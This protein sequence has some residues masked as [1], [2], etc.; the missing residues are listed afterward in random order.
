MK[1]FVLL[2]RFPYPLEKGDKLRAYHQIKQLS[3]NHDIHL[4]A[5]ND[6]TIRND[7][8]KALDPYCKSIH[9]L[10][11]S[12]ITI[13]WNILMAFFSGKPL[14]VG[15]FYNLHIQRNIDKLIDEIQPDHI[16]CQLLRVAEYV[17]KKKIPKTLDYQDVFS[18][19]VDRRKEISPFYWKP[20]LKLEYRRLCRYEK[21]LFDDF[22]NKTIISFP[23]RDF[24]P[25]PERNEIVVV[26]NGVDTDYFKPVETEKKYHLIFTGNMGYP[27][28]VNAAVFLVKEILPLIHKILPEVRIILAGAS[29]HTQVMELKSEK[30]EVT[31]WVEDIRP[32]YAS[33]RIF[34]AP[35]QIGTGLQNKLLEAMAMKIPCIT[36]PLA[37]YALGA[38]NGE[39]I[40]VGQTAPELAGLVI[41][42]LNDRQRACQL[43]EN[44]YHFV[45]RNFNWESATNKLEELISK[46]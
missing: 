24:I 27:P 7:Y 18:K 6:I 13:A 37:N 31:G 15:Y 35:M 40:M 2:S 36:S 28:N 17:R 45:H 3:R 25:H 38:K 21:K 11:L 26:T 14:Q 46:S 44:G 39:E 30:T 42:L 43:A 12:K 22:D 20:L 9:V 29:P 5:L 41:D 19:G 16:Y 33:A 4:C 10:N 23:D 34:I 1:I 32:Y 8:L